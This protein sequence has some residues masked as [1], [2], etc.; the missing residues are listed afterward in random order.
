MNSTLKIYLDKSGKKTTVSFEGKEKRVSFDENFE[1]TKMDIAAKF[2]G[3]EKNSRA[4]GAKLSV[5]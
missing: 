4:L 1:K 2:I 3:N 5:K